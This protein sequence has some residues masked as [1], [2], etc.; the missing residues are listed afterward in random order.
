MKRRFSL[1][2]GERRHL[3]EAG[4]QAP[5]GLTTPRWG[6]GGDGFSKEPSFLC[7][8]REA[9]PQTLGDSGGLSGHSFG[10]S[11]QTVGWLCPHPRLFIEHLLY[12]KHAP[13]AGSGRNAVPLL[14]EGGSRLRGVGGLLQGTRGH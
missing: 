2:L 6:R 4:F 5:V 8:S 9:I 12:D 13:C 7:S 10:A 14:G 11:W 1:V 3:L